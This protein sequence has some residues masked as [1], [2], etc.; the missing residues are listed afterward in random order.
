MAREA[1]LGRGG[2]FSGN[3]TFRSPELL[4]LALLYC[5]EVMRPSVLCV[6][7]VLMWSAA[8]WAIAGQSCG[9]MRYE[10][11]NQ[12]DYGPIRVRQLLGRAIDRDQTPVP[13]VCVGVFTEPDHKFIRAVETNGDGEFRL[14]TVPSGVYRLVAKYGGFGTANALL[15][16]GRGKSELVLRMRPAGI[17]T[18]SYIEAK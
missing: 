3:P 12:I 7:A 18:T 15:R 5:G 10:N 2:S 14:G 11:R 4:G 9:D 16:F 8:P 1:V 13:G 17:D 6:F